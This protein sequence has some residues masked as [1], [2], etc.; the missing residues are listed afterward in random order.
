MMDII[1]L[2]VSALLYV[3]NVWT[4]IVSGCANYNFTIGI[5]YNAAQIS[6]K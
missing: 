3:S 6:I 4:Q 2:R 1:I 5:K